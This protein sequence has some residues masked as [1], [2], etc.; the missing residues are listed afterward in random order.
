V[1]DQ[2]EYS[3]NEQKKEGLRIRDLHI[4]NQILI[5]KWMWQWFTQDKWWK[6]V[7]ITNNEAFRP[8]KNKHASL[9]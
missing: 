1:F 7:I 9:F 8:W 4:M 5:V 3:H 6:E 2:V